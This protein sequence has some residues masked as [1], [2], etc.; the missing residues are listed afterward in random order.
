M[1]HL[2]YG[3]MQA[4]FNPQTHAAC[5]WNKLLNELHLTEEAA[6]LAMAA[7]DTLGAKLRV[8]VRRV[9]RA[10]YVPE[11]VLTLLHLGRESGDGSL[12]L[13]ILH[14]EDAHKRK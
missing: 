2:L 10:H 8:F 7:N 13:R 5:D 14:R 11:D 6:L 9:H 3:Q 12:T 4:A 1:P